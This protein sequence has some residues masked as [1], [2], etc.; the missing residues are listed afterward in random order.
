MDIRKSTDE[1]DAAAIAD[2]QQRLRDIYVRRAGPNQGDHNYVSIAG[3]LIP[4]DY[5][6]RH[7]QAAIDA[8]QPG[9]PFEK[10][11]FRM[12]DASTTDLRE[13]MD[14]ARKGS[15]HSMNKQADLD[16]RSRN[17]SISSTSTARSL[18]RAQ[19]SSSPTCKIETSF[20]GP[21]PITGPSFD[22]G[23]DT[24]APSSVATPSGSLSSPRSGGYPHSF[25]ENE[26]ITTPT[27]A[28]GNGQKPEVVSLS[29][30]EDLSERN[31]IEEINRRTAQFP[32]TKQDSYANAIYSSAASVQQRRLKKQG[33]YE[34]AVES[35]VKNQA[36]IKRTK[37]ILQIRKQE[38]YTR[39]IGGSFEDDH[40]GEERGLFQQQQQQRP[41]VTSQRSSGGKMPRKQE[42]YL[43][44]VGEMSPENEEN[45]FQVEELTASPAHRIRKQDSYL[46]AV[47][48]LS[49]EDELAPL[50]SRQRISIRK[51]DSYQRAVLGSSFG[52]SVSGGNDDTDCVNTYGRGHAP[53]LHKQDSYQKAIL[54]SSFGS[55]AGNDSIDRPSNILLTRQENLDK[56][57]PRVSP[58]ISPK[59][60]SDPY[61]A[62]DSDKKGKVQKQES[63][64]KAIECGYPNYN[65]NNNDNN[66][67]GSID[68]RAVGSGRFSNYDDVLREFTEKGTIPSNIYQTRKEINE[69]QVYQ[70]QSYARN[71]TASNIN[72]PSEPLSMKKRQ[73]SYLQAVGLSPEEER[74]TTTRSWKVRQDSYQQAINLHPDEMVQNKPKRQDSYLQAISTFDHIGYTQNYSSVESQNKK[75]SF[76]HRQDSYQQAVGNISPEGSPYRM[77]TSNNDDLPDLNAQDVFD[78]AIKIQSVYRGFKTRDLFIFI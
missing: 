2:R 5:Y 40:S 21:K 45:R 25:A 16:R 14:R 38:S 36:V 11:N 62:S 70:K 10:Y 44:A 53:S 51:Q 58:R 57:S 50:P 67:G 60:G 41:V 20:C 48:G 19:D 9:G 69:N 7:Y 78:A 56:I 47:D 49:P 35:G 77:G 63:Y 73:D 26:D 39:A 68:N 66:N 6:K 15:T 61:N 18:R 37:Q 32:L 76:G 52:S 30:S 24:G 17:P 43:M 3:Q 34:A 29:G 4:I 27:K 64:T 31:L 22:A 72:R 1:L 8:Q 42:S 55:S 75:K 65:N 23:I 12:I 13:P 71:S 54:G 33:S 46:K 28:T 59:R 74:K